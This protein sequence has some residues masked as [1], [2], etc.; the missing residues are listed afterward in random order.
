MKKAIGWGLVLLPLFTFS[1]AT[2]T[3]K[4]ND[5][6]QQGNNS[7]IQD[8][9]A[10]SGHIIDYKSKTPLAG[11]TIH[12]K[13]TTHEVQTGPKGDFKFVTGQKNP[14][15]FIV[16]YVGYETLETTI[17]SYTNIV[18]SLKQASAQL[19]DVVVVGYG[20]QK[21]KA[22]I[23]A[24]S[25]INASETKSIPV[26]GFNEQ[27]QGK[28]P[29]VQINSNT[30]IP[31]DG[32]FVRVRGA[33]SIN[34][35]NDPLY[36][37]DGV[38]INNTSLQTVNT[39]G[40]ATSPIAD[41]NP[42]DIENIE[43]LKDASA[44]AIYGAR[45]ANGVVIITTK[46]GDYN[47]RA[48]V[49]ITY[50]QGW[51]AAPSL[52]NLT[53]GPEHAALVNEFYAN[54]YQDATT[55]ADK[56]KYLLPPFRAVTAGGRG[57]P[58]EQKTYDR[59]HELFRTAKLQDYNL[60]V[61]GGSKTTKYY[62]GGSYTNQEA[63]VKPLYFNRAAFKFNADQKISDQIQIGISN[64]FTR[65][66]R[67]QGRTG[68]GPAGGMLQSALHT[69][70][71]LPE[72]NADGTPARWAGFDNLQVLI[73]NYKVNTVSLRYIGNLYIDAEIIRNLK[74]RSSW[75][76]DYNNYDESEYWNDQTQLGAA[77]TSGLAT[78][79]LTQN[80]TW[81]NEQTLAYRTTFGN[82]NSIGILVGN[83]VQGNVISST[84]A[85]GS[86]FP[87]NSF[88]LISAAATRTA[89]QSWTKATLASFFSRI[90]YSYANKYFAEFSIR[91]DGSSR[92]GNNKKF[93]YFPSIGAGWRLKE[94]SFLKD[95]AFISDLKLRASY[96]VTG[97]QNGISNFAPLGLWSGGSGY[98]DNSSGDKPGIAPQQLAN[99]DLRWEKTSQ[100]NAGIDI[101]LLR[102]RI[103][104][105]FNVYAKNTTDNLLQL[106]VPGI[107]GFTTFYSNAGEISNRGFELAI[108]SINIKNKDFSWQTSFN[109]SGNSN[110][111]EKLGTPITQYNRDWVRLQ[112]G[113]SLYSFWLYKQ[114]SVDPQTG[115]AVFEDVNKDGQITVADR[116]IIGNA[117]PKVYGGLTNNLSYKGFDLGIL[118][119]FQSGNKVFN[120]NRFFGE[121]GGTRDAN[122]ILF[123]SQLNRWQK[124][125][126][127]T[128]VPRLTAF[129]NNYTLEQNSRFLE[130]GSFI[131]L[132]SLTFGY[133]I[134]RSITAKARLETV[135][136]YFSGTNLFTITKYT[137]P[138]P[139]VNV[140][141]NQNI[142]GL[143]LGT[144]PQ[145]RVIQF[146]INVTL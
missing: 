37:V 34:A 134:P 97:N 108:S 61:T 47:A 107:T 106:P 88:T 101:G 27:L 136:F 46:R 62:I 50:S 112:E 115:A 24:V 121:G 130:D 48:K 145:P 144:P 111:I 35:G 16:S 29:G 23:S 36:I 95:I 71:Y 135:R 68:D 14:V 137:G 25:S 57:L 13:G 85:Q 60:S 110:R 6:L 3:T 69:P 122:R 18:V 94:E 86:G 120:L 100:V 129:G 87:N 141:S 109:I 132:R 138:D 124:P 49:N 44:T 142:Q 73:N 66:F 4:K 31:G 54:S 80:T 119:S 116:Q 98:P 39:G 90:D 17:D 2:N 131:K 65:S 143:D 92:F 89:S 126:D 20:T 91:A 79:G 59:L 104:I 32:V 96:G 76:L 63:I 74:F 77:P 56:A 30:G 5:S 118:F 117:A 102:N 99:P 51:A 8:N 123:A 19:N 78:S 82:K 11:A 81:I 67:N 53:T 64:S 10:L 22:L 133:T 26:A 128:D 72:T 127:I 55:A 43:I 40:R 83:S 15:V 12:I 139:E 146:G 93:G 7:A 140:S 84:S 21:R 58:E 41:I 45:G 1:Q 28:A 105:E 42:A 75:S 9:I 33:T 38:F 125:G 70:T 52:W 113:Y 114:L 103:N